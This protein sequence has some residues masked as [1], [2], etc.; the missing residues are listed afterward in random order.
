M[1]TRRLDICIIAAVLSSAAC[2]DFSDIPQAHTVEQAIM[3]GMEAGEQYPNVIGLRIQRPGG[4]T[5][6]CS[7]T[8][9]A[10]NLV[11]TAQHCV[12]ELA[13]SFVI[14]GQSAFGPTYPPQAFSVTTSP[15]VQGAPTFYGADS[16]HIPPGGNDACGFDIALLVL[17]ENVPEGNATP[18]EPRLD[19]PVTPEE[20]YTAV[21]Y[22]HIGNFS[23]SGVRR[24]L[25][26]RMVTCGDG[27]CPANASVTDTEIVGSSGTCQGDSG[28]APIDSQGRVFGALSRGPSGCAGSVYS[29]TYAW[30]D[31]I[32][33]VAADA[34]IAG[35]YEA[36][37][38]VGGTPVPEPGEP[39][40]PPDDDTPEP[41]EEPTE[42]QIPA[43]PD[44]EDWDAD[45]WVNATDNC[46]QTV[47][48]QQI[49]TD[50]DAFGDACDLDDDNDRILDAFDPCPLSA[51][52][53]TEPAPHQAAP[54][55][56][57]SGE[58]GA[59]EAAALADIHAS[60]QA[61]ST[62]A[63]NNNGSG[64]SLLALLAL[65]VRRRRAKR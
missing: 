51:V 24:Y 59:V 9:I 13:S 27:T 65:V 26:N 55:A 31:F 47:N 36:P 29:S 63:A 21:G 40:L 30:A 53:D 15:T 2:G 56:A 5:G 45:G 3:G 46:P 41:S 6:L 35:G 28:G 8:L 20:V 1:T 38:W 58:A 7:G 32:R 25:D 42:E 61:C 39:T 14:C 34:A 52:C 43:N 33:G 12:A 19:Q 37:A 49:D 62:T 11:L 54:I 18:R 4:G 60:G 16:V 22:G 64:V 23:G 48:P 57:P 17:D 44:L 10:P 50:A